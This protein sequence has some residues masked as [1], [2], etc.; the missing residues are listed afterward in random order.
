MSSSE[1]ESQRQTW[2]TDRESECQSDRLME[3]HRARVSSELI[4]NSSVLVIIR[5]PRQPLLNYRSHQHDWMRL[6]N[7][8]TNLIIYGLYYYS[9]NC[10]GKVSIF[11]VLP[12]IRKSCVSHCALNSWDK[13]PQ[14]C[15]FRSLSPSKPQILQGDLV[16]CEGRNILGLLWFSRWFKFC[17]AALCWER[18][19]AGSGVTQHALRVHP[20]P[21][22]ISLTRV[23]LSTLWW[24][25]ASGRSSSASGSMIQP[26]WLQSVLADTLTFASASVC[27]NTCS[28]T[29][30]LAHIC[31]L[32]PHSSSPLLY[33][34]FSPTRY[35]CAMSLWLHQAMLQLILS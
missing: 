21:S 12:H 14:S 13:S 3:W 28:Y 26:A 15:P 25:W 33:F 8:N 11:P 20:L 16:L 1:R 34:S 23:L 30:S 22:N 29:L 2:Q 10:V 17:S 9:N 5:E 18:F 4:S 27:A 24:K 31:L 19:T 6:G 32:L 35:M 7:C